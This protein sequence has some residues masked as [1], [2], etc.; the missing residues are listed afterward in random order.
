MG[1]LETEVTESSCA[2]SRELSW[3]DDNEMEWLLNSE[4]RDVLSALLSHTKNA[5]P[6]EVTE[7]QVAAMDA[8]LKPGKRYKVTVKAEEIGEATN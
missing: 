5:E 2:V 4:H 8:F 1:N 6:E 7:N 3:F